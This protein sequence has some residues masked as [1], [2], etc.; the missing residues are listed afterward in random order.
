MTDDPYEEWQAYFK[1]YDEQEKHWKYIERIKVRYIRDVKRS[2]SG[3]VVAYLFQKVERPELFFKM[4]IAPLDLRLLIMTNKD[5]ELLIDQMFDDL[6]DYTVEF[7]DSDRPKGRK[8]WY[9]KIEYKLYSEERV[10]ENVREMEKM[11]SAPL[12]PAQRP[13][14]YEFSRDEEIS[15]D[16][17]E[18]FHKMIHDELK[19]LAVKYFPEISEITP[20]GIREIDSLLHFNMIWIG[21]EI[22]KIADI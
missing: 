13:D 1:F 5:I 15:Q 12:T 22:Y 3:V 20:T 14:F 17:A 2:L 10:L 19:R 4:Q 9:E 16:Y 18:R 8:L 21:D 7:Y 11:N 6:Y